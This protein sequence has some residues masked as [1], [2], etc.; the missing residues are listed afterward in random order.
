MTQTQ[1]V[2]ELL[3]RGPVTPR[4]ALQEIGCFRLAARVKDLRDQGHEIHSDMR[5][6]DEGK[7]Y[8]QYTLIKTK[9]A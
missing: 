4:D 9:A 8:A 3:R 2:L 6:T 1:Q 7:R 5:K